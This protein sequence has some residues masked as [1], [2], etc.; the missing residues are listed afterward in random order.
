M[1]T[2]I[3]IA[4]GIILVALVIAAAQNI[5]INVKDAIQFRKEDKAKESNTGEKQ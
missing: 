1:T 3:S 2:I 4:M 5:T